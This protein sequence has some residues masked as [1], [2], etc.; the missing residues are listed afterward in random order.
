MCGHPEEKQKGLQEQRPCEGREQVSGGLGGSV[1]LG[2][3]TPGTS[4]GADAGEKQR[5]N[6][7]G[8]GCLG[9]ELGFCP[10]TI[11]SYRRT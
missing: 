11:R 8:L 10:K 7:T 6:D 1:W 3:G 5:H 4:K 9:R 2:S